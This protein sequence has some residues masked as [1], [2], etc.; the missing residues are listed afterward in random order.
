[1]GAHWRF[2]G[3]TGNDLQDEKCSSDGD[4]D[5]AGSI[6]DRAQPD[7]HEE[8]LAEAGHANEANGRKLSASRSPGDPCAC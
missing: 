3:E 1:M 8:R 4:R 7:D 6:D 2:P 5:H